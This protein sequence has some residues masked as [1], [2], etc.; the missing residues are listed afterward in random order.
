MDLVKLN[1]NVVLNPIQYVIPYILVRIEASFNLATN[2]N[3]N[4][5]Y[6]SIIYC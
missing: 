2:E 4:R 1:R 6:Q 3:R 5:I